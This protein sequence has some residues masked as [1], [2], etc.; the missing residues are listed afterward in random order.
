MSTPSKTTFHIYV[1]RMAR[2]NQRLTRMA[3]DAPTAMREA[4]A[5]GYRVIRIV[6]APAPPRG[7]RVGG[8]R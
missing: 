6:R 8:P 4:E 2:G 7:G 5:D 1:A 3:V